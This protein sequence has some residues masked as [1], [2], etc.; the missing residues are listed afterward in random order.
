[1]ITQSYTHIYVRGETAVSVTKG[2]TWTKLA[3][4]KQA[5]VRLYLEGCEYNS[6]SLEH[7]NQAISRG[8]YMSM[9]TERL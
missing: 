4:N 3:L 7:I 8:L 5:L 1:M 2:V 9:L 6:R